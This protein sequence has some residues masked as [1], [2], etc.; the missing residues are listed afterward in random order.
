M[1]P[2]LRVERR[3]PDGVGEEVPVHVGEAG[4]VLVERGDALPL[5]RVQHLE[6]LHEQRPEVGPVLAGPRLQEV[7]QDVAGFEDPGVVGE[8]AEDD[9]HQEAFEVVRRIAGVPERVVELPDQLGGFDVRR[10]LVAEGPAR[11]PED[12]AELL[13]VRR[14]RVEPEGH[15]VPLEE[16]VELEV[17]EVADQD[18]A[19]PLALGERVEVAAGLFVG[20]RQVA[21]GALLLDDQDSRPEEVNEAAGVVELFDP[22]LVAGD[23]L[24]AHPEDA[25]EVVVKALGL[26]LLVT[27]VRP[28]PGEGRGAGADLVPGEAHGGGVLF[29]AVA[30]VAALMGGKPHL[31]Y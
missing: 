8:Q 19:R 28:L 30:A 9:P 29:Q 18:V 17:L 16:V 3:N 5:R 25:E 21:P 14:Q 1:R 2:H 24:P 15:L 26:A 13:D 20:R 4:E 7:E 31:G 22:L 27:R 23:R 12:E 11:D 10:V 6:E